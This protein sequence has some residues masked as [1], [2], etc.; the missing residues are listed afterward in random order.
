MHGIVLRN[1]GHN[2]KI[3]ESNALSEQKN[4]GA[5]IAAMDEVHTFMPNFSKATYTVTSQNVQFLD[6]EFKVRRKLDVSLKMTIR[7]CLHYLMRANFDGLRSEICCPESS[8]S[9]ALTGT[10]VY[11][12]G[13]NVVGVEYADGA[14]Y[15]NI[16]RP[17]NRRIWNRTCE[18]RHCC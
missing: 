12:H 15:G 10:A 2:V 3:L 11:K 14:C 8:E 17:A 9:S 16:R 7:N 4:L 18:S 6:E 1:L 13:K 5:G